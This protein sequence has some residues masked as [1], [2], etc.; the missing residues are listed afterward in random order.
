MLNKGSNEPS[1]FIEQQV[2]LAKVPSLRKVDLTRRPFVIALVVLLALLLRAWAAW[3]LPRDADEPV[4]QTAGY[5]YA[6]LIKAG[7]WQGVI[8]YPNVREHP[9]LVKLLYSLPYLILDESQTALARQST[10]VFFNRGVAVLFGTLT[11]LLLAL[12]DPLAGF[13]LAAHSMT[14]K[15]TSEVYLEAVPQALALLAVL[16][17]A[18]AQQIG[19]DN[20]ARAPW[21][22]LVLS[23]LAV[24]AAGAGKYTYLVVAPVIAFLALYRRALNWKVLVVYAALA[25]CAFWLFDPYLWRDPLNRLLG[26][27]LCH[28]GYTHSQDVLRAGYAWYQPLVWI[29]N[30]VPWHA[31]VF[32]FPVTDEITFWL[33]LPGLYLA[34]RK[35]PWASVWVLLAFVV[36]LLWPT[37]WPQYTLIYTAPVCLLAATTARWLYAKVVTE[38]PYW[39]TLREIVPRPS[40][41]MW[42]VLAVFVVA[43]V[44]W[45][46]VYEAQ[47]AQARVGWSLYSSGAAPLPSNTINAIAVGS[48]PAHAYVPMA[49]GTD[50][51]ALLWT[52]TPDSPW[53][54]APQEFTP[55]NSGLPSARVLAVL[56]THDGAWWFGTDN[57]VARFDGA[58]Y[59]WQ[60]FRAAD[61]KLP[62]AN[63]RALQEDMQGGI[64]IGTLSGAAHWDGAAW[65]PFVAAPNRLLDNNVFAIATLGDDVWFGTLDG[66]SRL[67]TRSGTWQTFR[68]RESA[69]G[70]RGVNDL[71]VSSD[72]RLWAA[73]AGGGLG[74]W[75]GKTWQFQR[76]QNSTLP[77]N[78]VTRLVETA[79]GV[80][81]AGFG[82]P[83]EPGGVLARYDGQAQTWRVYSPENS[84]HSGGEAL[85]LARDA[86]GRLWVGLA[87]G[88]LEIYDQP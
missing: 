35:T 12:V 67:N 56:R 50:N 74:V 22:W 49:L 18:R 61:L 80:L 40:R 81:W 78:I 63:V 32:F 27:L 83:T 24:G 38:N 47:M 25:V 68:L 17:F 8:D 6:Q 26:S 60:D 3:Q 54:P 20:N 58:R 1:R 69:L 62:G 19:A 34:V 48:A 39:N 75:D 33:A 45:R 76:T 5:D 41:A 65:T 51:G 79:P 28:P 53:G 86:Q 21:R 36:L 23:A 46:V 30:Q 11:V 71:L 10:A 16:A 7:D 82:F 88:G 29:S 2:N 85:A 43:L 70:W 31:Q 15:Y 13:L 72:G 44:G 42:V 9:A 55:Q 77:H 57:G 37:K 87:A 64:W 84:G 52:P 59:M 4:Y 14:I 66:I 73:T